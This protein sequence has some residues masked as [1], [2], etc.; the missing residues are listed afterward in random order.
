MRT[1]VH[2]SLCVQQAA[3]SVDRSKFLGWLEVKTL[4]VLREMM[5]S[6]F[7]GQ[8]FTP[9]EWG[10]RPGQDSRDTSPGKLL[11]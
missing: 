2:L 6:C 9:L 11:L 4:T 8:L 7:C 3:K 10:R 5:T 1:G